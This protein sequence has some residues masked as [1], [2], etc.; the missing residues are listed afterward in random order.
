L[1]GWRWIF[2]VEGAMT[3]VAAIV[4]RFFIVNFPQ[5]ARFLTNDEKDRVIQR[6]NKDRGDGEHDQITFQ[7]V[8][9]YLLNWQLWAFGLIVYLHPLLVTD[10]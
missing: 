2:I 3:I 4:A 1:A 5:L 9:H 10:R 8:V 6:L 7:K